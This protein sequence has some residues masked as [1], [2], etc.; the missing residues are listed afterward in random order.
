MMSDDKFRK[1]GT[2][3]KQQGVYFED[4]I[5]APSCFL[6]IDYDEA[7]TQGFGGLKLSDG[8]DRVLGGGNLSGFP[9][10][11]SQGFGGQTCGGALQLQR[12]G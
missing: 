3:A 2:F 12:L 6:Y 7:G 9:G 8:L 5:G 4:H 10:Q 11:E 1:A